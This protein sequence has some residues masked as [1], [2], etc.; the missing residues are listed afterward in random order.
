[1]IALWFGVVGLMLIM[2]VTLDGRNFGAGCHW[3]V[4]KTPQERRQVVAAIGPLVW[5]EV[6]LV[7][8]AAH[9]SLCFPS[10]WARRSPGITWR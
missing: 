9:C 4:A 6:W 2:Y 8:S 5:H 1:M 7:V 3:L 10:S